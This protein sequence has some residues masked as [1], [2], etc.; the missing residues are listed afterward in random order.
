MTTTKNYKDM[1]TVTIKFQA[2]NF[3][4]A[5]IYK[6]VEDVDGSTTEMVFLTLDSALR[7]SSA[8][9]QYFAALNIP[10]ATWIERT[11]INI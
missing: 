5:E 6:V 11:S 9:R 10:G 2:T 8:R 7:H 4:S 3:G 1:E